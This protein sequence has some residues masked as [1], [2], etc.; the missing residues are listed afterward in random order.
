MTLRAERLSWKPGGAFVLRS[1]DLDARAGAITAIVGVNGS[2]KSALL[3]LLA[4][5]G[6][7][8]SGTVRWQDRRLGR[9]RRRRFGYLAQD[10][11]LSTRGTPDDV[12][13]GVLRPRTPRPVRE[14]VVAD[15]LDHRRSDTTWS[16]AAL[17]LAQRR[18]LLVAA[19]L[20]TGPT[21]LVL[22]EPFA[23]LTDDALPAVLDRLR[24]C[25]SAGS[26]V[27]LA[28]QRLDLVEEVADDLV[29]L[30]EGQVAA[31][32]R[33]VVPNSAA[34]LLRLDLEGPGADTGWLREHPGVQ[35]VDAE[36]GSAVIA[37]SDASVGQSV[38]LE[39][40]GR[41][42]IGRF[43]PLTGGLRRRVPK[44]LLHV[45]PPRS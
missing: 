27:L 3:R 9:S 24:A 31:R 19:V 11:G 20:D 30:A 35:V 12:V 32:T 43:G 29:V 17:S 39:A 26:A 2:G 40:A 7:P 22:D 21:V 13:R 5:I 6:R 34:L 4:G 16:G 44:N 33:L 45:R 41:G 36:A 14:A 38:L 1:V 42:R 37:V 18:E 23:G 25:A 10:A 15:L 8:H 28:T